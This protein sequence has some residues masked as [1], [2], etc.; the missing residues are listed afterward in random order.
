MIFSSINIQ[1]NIISSDILTKISQDDIRYQKPSDFNL[2]NNTAVRDEIGIAWAI[3]QAHWK[4]FRAKKENLKTDDTGTTITRQYWM[5]PFMQALGYDLQI[6]KAELIN[7]KSYAISHRAINK[8]GFPVHIVGVNQ[9]LDDRPKHGARLSPHAL[10]QEYLN[11]HEHLYALTSNGSF[12]RVLRDATRL[13]RLSYLEFDLERMMEEELYAEFALL[14][15]VLHA[16]RMADK[17]DAAEDSIFEY[18]HQEALASGTRIRERLSEAVEKTIRLLGNGLI[19]HPQNTSLREL[20]TQDLNADQYYLYLL[21]AVY[22]ILFLLVIEERHL[23]YPEKRSEEIQ[24]KRRFYYDFY[25]IQRLTKLA[26]KR[27]Y[28]DPRKTDLWEGLLSTFKLFES[29]QYGN[30]LGIQALGSGLFA[31]EAI[32]IL[33]Q[34]KLD[35]ETLL[36]VLRYLVMFENENKQWTRVNYADLDVEEFGSVYEGLLEYQ[37]V[38]KIEHELATFSFEQGDGRSSSG[39][40]YTPEELVKPLIKH[41]LDYIIEDKLKEGK[42]KATDEY[43][44]MQAQCDALLTITVC[45]VACGSG[46][47]LLSA[48]RRI[49]MELAILRESIEGRSL[50]EQP[51]PKHLRKAIRDVIRFCIYGVDLNPLAVELCKVALWLEAHNPNEPLNFLDHHIKNGNAIVGLAHFKELENGIASEAF[52]TLPGDEKEI[53]GTFKKKNDKERKDRAQ[54][55]TYDLSAADDSLKGLRKDFAVFVALPE[56]TPEQIAAKAEAYKKLTTGSKWFRLKNMADLQV[57]Q[58]FIPKTMDNK[59]KLTTDAQYRTYLNAGTQILDR[60]ASMA[61]AQDKHFFHWFL[62]FPQVFSNGGFDCIL[63]NPPFKGGSKISSSLGDSYLQ[64]IKENNEESK[65]N[66]DLV[67]YFFRRNY[68]IIKNNGFISLISTNTISQGDTRIFAL[69]Y[70]IKNKKACINHAISSIRWPGDAAVQISIVTLTKGRTKLNVFLDGKEVQDISSLLNDSIDIGNPFDLV[71]NSNISSLGTNVNGDGFILTKEE[72]ECF[73]DEEQM[74]IRGYMNGK[75]FNNTYT[76]FPQRY[77]IDFKNYEKEFCINKYPNLFKHVEEK[78]LPHRRK[79]KPSN[80]A[81]KKWWLFERARL[82]FYDTISSKEMILG[83]TQVSKTCGF[84]FLSTNNLYDQR[85]VLINADQLWV[86][87]IL[88]SSI[89]IEW[90]WKYGSTM[91]S[92]LTYNS[93]K[94]LSTFPFLHLHNIEKL[95]ELSGNYYNDRSDFLKTYQIGLREFYNEFHKNKPGYELFRTKHKQMDEAVL[96]AYG[97]HEDSEKWGKAINLAHGFYEVDYLPEND[98][99][100]YTINPEARKEVLKRLLLLNHE[101]YEEEIMQ[102]LHK[103]ADVEK[104]YADKGQPIPEGVE[105]SDKKAKAKTKIKPKLK[106]EKISDAIQQSLFTTENEAAM[107]EF[108]V[109]EG[110]YSIK[111]VA[112]II[113]QSYDKVRRWFLKLSNA[114]YEGLDNTGQKDIDQRRISFHGLVEIVVIGTLLENDF[115]LKTIF[116]ARTDL[117]KKSNRIYPFA[118]NNVRDN[119]KVAGKSIIFEFPDGL[120]TLDGSGQF[121]LELIR[122][123]FR[124]IEFNTSGVAQRLVPTKG[125]RKIVIDPKVGGGKPS[126]KEHEGIQVETVMKFY[127][128][129]DSIPDLMQ[130]YGISKDEIKAAI[131]YMS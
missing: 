15:R 98:H 11:N 92:D 129:E 59:E 45:D 28:V 86:F 37:P 9:K 75:E 67:G 131:A 93:S 77:I 3:A 72:Q 34:Q 24:K 108:G 112:D 14:F 19:K 4:G 63:G 127:D 23:I 61:I 94:I 73:S 41:S 29:E 78:V 42:A 113:G 17:I 115:N 123:F 100:R 54:L 85:I 64:Y 21:R 119:L 120:V 122:D 52:K 88:Q 124:D 103:K 56:N 68:N 81:Y 10:V 90:A 125:F 76:F 87:G 46:H 26:E 117:A 74:L 18:Y 43:E 27:V 69:E 53:A 104:F 83:I 49:G 84:N 7:E 114:Q 101:R 96:E 89:H 8:E 65:G 22:R 109:H 58:F 66:V 48:A 55:T 105:F 6:A 79:L 118:T 82:N 128:G 31:P 40:H 5:V 47:I 16:T 60:G 121:N 70:L 35:N 36:L 116:K 20:A 71:Q 32:G 106:E 111:D 91:K 13:A 97:W 126:F 80:A 51:S 33:T 102:G 30:K 57:A 2:D 12:L 62:E 38:I 50:V 25:S 95:D 107:R 44:Q 130:D 39:S 1:G 99:T 110:I